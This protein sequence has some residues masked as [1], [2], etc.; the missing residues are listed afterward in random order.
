MCLPYYRFDKLGE[1][2]TTRKEPEEILLF[3]KNTSEIIYF[4][5]DRRGYK[6]K[7]APQRGMSSNPTPSAKTV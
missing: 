7:N 4:G 6:K 5:M 1:S 2:E 3:N